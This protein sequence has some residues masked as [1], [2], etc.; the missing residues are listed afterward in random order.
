[1]DY[2]KI[3]ALIR[4]LRRERGLTQRQ[5]AEELGLSPKTVSKWERALGCPD[6]SLVPALAACL[7]VDAAALLAGEL[8]ENE[9]SGGNMRK[10]R[11]FVC[12]VC[13]SLSCSTG[14]AS[15]SCC[16]RPLEALE[17]NKA[18]PEL[19]LRVTDSDGDWYVESGHPARKDDYISFLALVT[20]DRLLVLRQYP[21]WEIH[22]RIPGRPHGK[23][24]WY[25]TTR[26][27]FYQ[28]V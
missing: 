28:L 13:G 4:R 12:P 14:E 15:V 3:G 10:T 1:M 2:E 20:G 16:G 8:A 5:L 19:A 18:P 11:F 6:V 7:Q 23:L 21:E 22:A 25:S 17:P 27:F 26:G 24:V 9:L